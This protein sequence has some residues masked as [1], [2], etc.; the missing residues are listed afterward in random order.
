MTFLYRNHLWPIP[1]KVSVFFLVLGLTPTLIPAAPPSS[2]A[3][4]SPD[5]ACECV[6][7]QVRPY[8]VNT[9]AI[10]PPLICN[11]GDSFEPAKAIGRTEFEGLSAGDTVARYRRDDGVDIDDTRAASSSRVTHSNCQCIYAPRFGSVRNVTQI[12]EESL[13]QGP[14][15]LSNDRSLASQITKQPTSNTAQLTSLHM[16]RKSNS[17]IA[18]EERSG[19]LGVDAAMLPNQSLGQAKPGE[20]IYD[21]HINSAKR[22]EAIAESVGV[23]IPIAWTRLTAANAVFNDQQADVTSSSQGIAI[24]RVESLGRAELTLCKR[25][26]SDSARIGEEIDFTIAFLNSGDVPLTDIVIMDV[27]P[28]RL[29]LIESSAA[30]SIPAE[31]KMTQEDDGTTSI[32]WQLSS[33]LGSGESGFVRMRTIL[34]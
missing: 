26:G 6:E 3:N 15:G 9:P 7:Y 20:S 29:Q 11:G 16:A 17:G 1:K 8:G 13:P 30:S 2:S 27:L 31:I 34:R 22:K 10:L 25:S 32:S 14:A 28:Q 33:T 24:L 5:I 12:H 4:S 18:V 19:P 21:T 23:D